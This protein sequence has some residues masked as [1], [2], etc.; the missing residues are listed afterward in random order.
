M[1]LGTRSVARVV[2]VV[3]VVIT[4][5]A[6]VV[7]FAKKRGAIRVSIPYLIFSACALAVG[8]TKHL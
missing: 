6:V 8:I 4:V 3:V 2:I 7:T 5:V 1:G